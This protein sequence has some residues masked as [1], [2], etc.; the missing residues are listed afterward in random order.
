MFFLIGI[1]LCGLPALCLLLFPCLFFRIFFVRKPML[2]NSLPEGVEV[3]VIGLIGGRF[4]VFGHGL[5]LL[6]V[7]GRVHVVRFQ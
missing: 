2:F 6:F 4:D 3:I 7:L 5:H 1:L